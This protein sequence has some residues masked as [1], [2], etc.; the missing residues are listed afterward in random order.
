MLRRTLHNSRSASSSLADAS[1]KSP[2]TGRLFRKIIVLFGRKPHDSL[3]SQCIA[4][5][6]VYHFT[7]IP[8]QKILEHALSVHIGNRLFARDTLQANSFL[9]NGGHAIKSDW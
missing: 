6:S 1:S 7:S 4:T 9:I 2:K 5:A 3:C 8:H